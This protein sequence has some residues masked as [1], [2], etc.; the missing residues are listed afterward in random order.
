MS[1]VGIEAATRVNAGWKM[2]GENGTE[3][4]LFESD[5]SSQDLTDSTE[6]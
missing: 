6:A 1:K 3:K 4:F 5:S 2:N